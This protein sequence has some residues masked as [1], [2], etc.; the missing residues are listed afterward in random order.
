M[1]AT[2]QRQYFKDKEYDIPRKGL[3]GSGGDAAANEEAWRVFLSVERYKYNKLMAETLDLCIIKR[4]VIV[5]LLN[6]NVSNQTESERHLPLAD[7][8]TQKSEPRGQFP[9]LQTLN[10]KGQQFAPQLP[11]RNSRILLN[12]TLRLKL[13]SWHVFFTIHMQRI[14]I[15]L[16]YHVHLIIIYIYILD[17]RGITILIKI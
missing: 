17:S 1:N 2:V 6:S 10:R 8:I 4:I 11:R 15:Y 3:F 13:W 16:T 14:I 12:Q 7:Y 5:Q 9:C